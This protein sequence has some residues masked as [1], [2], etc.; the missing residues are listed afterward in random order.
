[1]QCAAT[2]VSGGSEFPGSCSVALTGV[3]VLPLPKFTYVPACFLNLFPDAPDEAL[4]HI[5]RYV[6]PYAASGQ[7][8]EFSCR[9]VGATPPRMPKLLIEH[10]AHR[11][12]RAGLRIRLE[13][14]CVD[15]GTG[16]G[17]R[18]RE[19]VGPGV[20]VCEYAGEILRDEEAEARCIDGPQGRDAYL[21]NLTTP[22][23]WR[24]LGVKPIDLGL[25]HGDNTQELADE[26]AFVIDAYH[27][28]NI[29][30]FI[31][32]ACGKSRVA[33]LTPVFVFTEEQPGMPLDVRLPRVA[34]FSNRW[35][36]AGEELRYDY[37]MEPGTVDDVHGACRSLPCYCKSEACR[38]RIY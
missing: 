25:G 18:T 2:D 13:V 31:N 14:F 3:D 35:I 23:D 15:A 28:G 11:V 10:G 37:A 17:V 9:V 19:A 32:H 26:P 33:N 27:Y 16:W 36:E 1:M 30:R 8:L 29:A 4:E 20:F 34:L 7:L 12:V 6:S 22:S 5:E 21:F 38:G 24:A